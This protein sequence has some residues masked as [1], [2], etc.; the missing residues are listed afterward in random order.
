MPQSE[1]KDAFA[2]K[3]SADPFSPEPANVV[4]TPSWVILRIFL[5]PHSATNKLPDLSTTIP[6]RLLKVALPPIPSVDQIV[7]DP[8][9]FISSR[10]GVIFQTLLLI[11]NCVVI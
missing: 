5:P 8:A 1:L 3:P 10:S 11:R 6:R 2:P 9:N 7:D 4:T